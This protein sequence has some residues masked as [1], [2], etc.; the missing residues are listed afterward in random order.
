MLPFMFG[1][2]PCA[3]N[4]NYVGLVLCVRD[5]NYAITFRTPNTQKA[6]LSKRMIRV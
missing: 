2:D 4:T 5:N 3:D 6:I 1:S